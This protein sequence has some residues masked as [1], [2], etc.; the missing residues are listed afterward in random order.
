MQ[1][2][3]LSPSGDGDLRSLAELPELLFGDRQQ[4]G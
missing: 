4:T 2:L 3:L 1:A